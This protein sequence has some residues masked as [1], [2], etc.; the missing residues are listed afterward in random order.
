MKRILAFLT[1]MALFIAGVTVFTS[2]MDQKL[3]SGKKSLNYM[4]D[5]DKY[6]CKDAI[7]PSLDE[8]TIL[9][10]GSSE[11]GMD[12]AE[13]HPS[14]LFNNGNS[15]FNMMLVGGGYNQSLSHAM[16]I[17]AL[18]EEMTVKKAVLNLSPQ[19]FTQAHLDPSAF[20]NKFYIDI[21][22]ECMKNPKLSPY[23]KQKIANRAKSLLATYPDGLEQ[24]TWGENA[25]ARKP[26]HP[27][28]KLQL[29]LSHSFEAMRRK[30][31]LT[32]KYNFVPYTT[33][34][35]LYKDIDFDKMMKISEEQG[36]AACTNNV[37]YVYDEY[38]TN[39]IEPNLDSLKN[40]S[41]EKSYCDSPEY[42]DLRLFLDVCKELEIT[43]M[44]SSVP[45]NGF[46]YDYIGF[47]KADRQQYYQN[48]R[49]IA[50]EYEVEL[51]DLSEHEYT[52]YFLRD[53]MHLGWKG[54]TY[55]V[56]GVHD[57]YSED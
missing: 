27:L 28:S 13:A 50:A 22:A 6:A 51:L 46:W 45:V 39:Y 25:Y 17:G 26:F 19:W 7:A 42:D 10:L 8:N 40:S 12:N 3:V 5:H 48:L 33:K 56:Q 23:V 32:K 44:L 18:S 29:D 55:I 21:F 24:V 16:F 31:I 36:Q 54:W 57:F 1:A 38:Y 15:D 41:T 11:L 47:P 43:P 53:V 35:V 37:F 14:A 4:I 9:F 52:P 2:S 30:N 49:D 34:K 20:A